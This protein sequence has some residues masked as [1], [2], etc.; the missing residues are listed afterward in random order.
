MNDDGD[1]IERVDR[2]TDGATISCHGFIEL[3]G[4]RR[5][6]QAFE[7]SNE[8]DLPVVLRAAT[9][10]LDAATIAGEMP[11][12]GDLQWRSILPRESGQILVYFDLADVGGNTKN[13]LGTTIKYI[14]EFEI[15]GK[16]ETLEWS[17]HRTD[18]LPKSRD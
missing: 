14:C 4:S 12:S 2:K 17:L 3:I 8:S 13:A 5:V 10:N 18:R 7:V 11:A 9:L 1:L 16:I 15:G 6:E